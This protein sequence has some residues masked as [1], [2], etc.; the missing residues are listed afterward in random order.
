MLKVQL[1][2]FAGRMLLCAALSYLAMGISL[3]VAQPSRPLVDELKN[4]FV[5][6]MEREEPR[7]STEPSVVRTRAVQVNVNLLAAS[8]SHRR[9][10]L[11]LNLFDDV[12]LVAIFERYEVRSSN[13][14]TWFGRLA[15]KEYSSFIFV[16]EQGVMV[17][18]IRVPGKGVYE[19]SFPGAG[20][21]VIQEIDESKFPPCGV[22]S[23]ERL[24]SQVA[25]IPC[26]V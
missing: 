17:G 7:A 9:D 3:T 20:V 12:S 15:N 18:T 22:G 2:V 23:A 19:I 16:V 26:A 24:G 4:L 13:S 6:A 10:K 11:R 8:P 1:S 25:P 14:Y 21:H 5:N